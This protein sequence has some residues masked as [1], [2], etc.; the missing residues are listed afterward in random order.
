M[1]QS[2]ANDLPDRF[3]SS[4]EDDDDEEVVGWMGE[5]GE[6]EPRSRGNE[7]GDEE[8]DVIREFGRRALFQERWEGEFQ[9]DDEFEFRAPQGSPAPETQDNLVM[10][11]LSILIT[12]EL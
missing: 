5:S 2:L 8:E 7:G 12:A 3:G 10:V 1:S 11:L 4:D 6:F 9:D